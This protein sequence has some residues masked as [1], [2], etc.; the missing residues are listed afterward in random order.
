VD[1]Y[2]CPN[3]IAGITQAGMPR[4]VLAVAYTYI[5]L[6]LLMHEAGS[7]LPR[8]PYRYCIS[9]ANMCRAEI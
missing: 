1:V 5:I 8:D 6:Q 7:S 2:N 4:E 9:K 3:W